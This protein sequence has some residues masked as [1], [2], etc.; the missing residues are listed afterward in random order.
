[1]CLRRTGGETINN[2]KVDMTFYVIGGVGY[3]CRWKPERENFLRI[4]IVGYRFCVD[5]VVDTRN[6]NIG[7]TEKI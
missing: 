4:D 7:V 2:L 6:N 3:M 5:R 1:M